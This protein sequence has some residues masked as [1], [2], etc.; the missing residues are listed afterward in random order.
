VLR[1]I[2]AR[3]TSANHPAGA[4]LTTLALV[5]GL[6]LGASVAGRGQ[7]ELPA[8]LLALLPLAVS[9]IAVSRIDASL[10]TFL[11]FAGYGPAFLGAAAAMLPT[12]CGIAAAAGL[13]LVRAAPV[14][15]LAAAL[16]TGVAVVIALARTW[17]YPGRQKRAVDFQL[18]VEL[19]ALALIGVL[20]LPLA[21]LALLWRLGSFYRHAA[22][23]RWM[24]P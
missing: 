16:L 22:G 5:F 14:A 4:A 15:L 2:V 17:L 13:S 10:C 11:S 9:L 24:Q 21:P 23:R 1:A 19:A 12:A 6:T 8:T 3:Q 7:P 18:Q 20:V